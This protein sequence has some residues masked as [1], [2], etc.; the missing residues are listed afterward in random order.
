MRNRTPRLTQRTA[1][2]PRR[3]AAKA[4]FT[5]IELL[6]VL[7]ILAVLAALIVPRIAGR[8]ED[9]RKSAAKAD[10]AA[11]ENSLRMFEIDN[12]RFPSTD[13][14]LQALLTPPNGVTADPA[15]WPYLT[16]NN[17]NDPWGHPYQYR[18]PG[19]ANKN[20]YDVFSM[21]IDGREGGGD[22]IDN[23]SAK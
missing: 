16:K 3:T 7:V 10:I 5:L 17:T 23:W 18:Y 21:G 15:K 4:A 1:R 6:L 19:T 22:D 8:G 20:G 11:I 14:G 9:A 12:S 2:R 13:E